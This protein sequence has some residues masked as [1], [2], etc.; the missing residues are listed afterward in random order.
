MDPSPFAQR[1][2]GHLHWPS[3]AYGR[4]VEGAAL[5]MMERNMGADVSPSAEC[6]L[7]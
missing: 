5:K 3:E 6:L 1:D 4:S 2:R 7:R